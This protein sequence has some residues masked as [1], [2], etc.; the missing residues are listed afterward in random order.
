MKSYIF[1]FRHNFDEM[2]ILLFFVK[3]SFDEMKKT[4]FDE[5]KF[6]EMKSSLFFKVSLVFYIIIPKMEKI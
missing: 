2:K 6:D 3:N 4:S 1:Y 5:M